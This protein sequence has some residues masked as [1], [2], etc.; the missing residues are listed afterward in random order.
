MSDKKEYTPREMVSLGKIR[1]KEIPLA[2]E[3]FNDGNYSMETRYPQRYAEYKGLPAPPTYLIFTTSGKHV[4]TLHP[5]GDH[6]CLEEEF[7]HLFDKMVEVI[8]LAVKKAMS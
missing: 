5:Y 7:H 6:E 3:K 8:E 1:R 4:A 2:F